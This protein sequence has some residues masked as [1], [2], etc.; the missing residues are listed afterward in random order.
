MS[1]KNANNP[2]DIRHGRVTSPPSRGSQAMDLELLEEWQVVELEGG[3]NFP[4]TS[5]GAF[6]GHSEDTQ[7]TAPP[8]DDY[9]LSGGREDARDCINFTDEELAKKKAGAKWNRQD[10][11]AGETFEVE[12]KYTMRHIT[13]GYRW[14][15]TKDGWDE[16]VRISR[17]QLD[18]DPFFDDLYTYEPYYDHEADMPPKDKHSVVLPTGKSGHHLILLLWIVADTGAAFYQT[19]DVNFVEPASKS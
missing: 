11:R 1:K 6:P 18:P 19:F 13:R 9:I 2:R 10:V 8:K 3:K 14:F 7:S 5:A 16:N 12:W 17:A 15:I 4:A